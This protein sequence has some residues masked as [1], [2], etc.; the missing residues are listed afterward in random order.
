MAVMWLLS[1]LVM[2]DAV[3]QDTPDPRET[4]QE[5]RTEERNILDHI[6]AVDRQLH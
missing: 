1:L 3:A 2:G 4:L 6:N 5:A